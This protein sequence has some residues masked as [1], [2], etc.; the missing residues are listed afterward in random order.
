MLEFSRSGRSWACWCPP[1]ACRRRA[2]RSSSLTLWRSC[3]FHVFRA[4]TEAKHTWGKTTEQR[5]PQ[6]K[7]QAEGGIRVKHSLEQTILHAIDDSL[8][9]ARWQFATVLH[10]GQIGHGKLP[11]AQRLAE[12]VCCSYGIHNGIVN[13]VPTS[14]RHDVCS[15]PDQQQAGTIPAR[16]TIR[17]NGEHRD[18]F[19]VLQFLGAFGH[20]RCR[21]NDRLT[22]RLQSCGA[23]LLIRP[24]ANDIADLPE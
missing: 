21:L 13:P 4:N 20:L 7:R 3:S 6:K 18:G 9:D 8:N 17:G 11:T 16:E 15:V 14:R 1:A 2:Q 22:Q 12:D 5:Q 19:P 23:H 10:T 24:L